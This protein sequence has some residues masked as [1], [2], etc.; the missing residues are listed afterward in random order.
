LSTLFDFDFYG[1]IRAAKFAHFTADTILPTRGNHLV[2][3]IKFQYILWAKM[4]AYA[5]P[6]APFPIYY[7]LF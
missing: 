5:T 1:K 4:D 2:L 3:F 6:F 7:M